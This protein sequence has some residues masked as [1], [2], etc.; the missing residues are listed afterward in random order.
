MVVLQE[1]PGDSCHLGHPWSNSL[2]RFLNPR[3]WPQGLAYLS[4]YSSTCHPSHKARSGDAHQLPAPAPPR[5]CPQARSELQHNL[6]EAEHVGGAGL[7]LDLDGEHRPSG[8]ALA[9]E[10]RATACRLGQAMR[11][12]HTE[13]VDG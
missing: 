13:V 5:L 11:L 8:R 7:A 6:G 1:A 12:E 10:G 3:L 2:R 4:I 9:D